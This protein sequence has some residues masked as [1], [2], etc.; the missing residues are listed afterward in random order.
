MSS[1]P[2]APDTKQSSKI[3]VDMTRSSSPEERHTDSTTEAVKKAIR[4]CIEDIKQLPANDEA[5]TEVAEFA[6]NTLP[7]DLPSLP[8]GLSWVR[9]NGKWIAKFMD[10]ASRKGAFKLPPLPACIRKKG[11]YN[12]RGR[13]VPSADITRFFQEQQAEYAERKAKEQAEDQEEKGE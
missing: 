2:T 6:S 8:K 7:E 11:K 3:V 1:T 10:S 9:I 5:Q 4:G 12:R 13:F